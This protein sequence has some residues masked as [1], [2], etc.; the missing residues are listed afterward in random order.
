MA[1]ACCRVVWLPWKRAQFEP[2]THGKTQSSVLVSRSLARGLSDRAG[3][4]NIVSR[5]LLAVC[6]QGTH[7]EAV[8]LPPI[9]IRLVP[10]VQPQHPG[11][12]PWT[13]MIDKDGV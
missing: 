3:N 10:G 8:A 7:S 12:I 13:G 4:H 1:K 2:N 5:I 9:T 6:A 11:K